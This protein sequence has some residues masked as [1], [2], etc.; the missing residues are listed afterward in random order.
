MKVFHRR[1]LTFGLAIVA[2]FA[3]FATAFAG[4]SHVY[5]YVGYSSHY[6]GPSGT[7]SCYFQSF[8]W[9]HSE[10]VAFHGYY[11]QTQVQVQMVNQYNAVENSPWNFTWGAT[12]LVDG[13]SSNNSQSYIE[14]LG[15]DFT[16]S[17]AFY[18]HKNLNYQNPGYNPYVMAQFG[19]AGSAT[20]Q[21]KSY[22]IIHGPN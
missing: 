8:N 16:D 15:Y 1:A 13:I 14:P 2:A 18:P 5:P 10:G 3:L 6:V 7:S 17:V 4:I 22:V 20:C 9:S 21:T 11:P 19:D 12:W